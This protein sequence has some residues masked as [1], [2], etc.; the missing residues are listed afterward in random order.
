MARGL[1]VELHYILHAQRTQQSRNGDA[2][3]RVDSV[4]GNAE[5]GLGNG[6]LVDQR[7][8][9]HALDVGIDGVEILS[10]GT[11]VVDLGET[12]LV[13]LGQAQHLVALGGVDELALGVEQ[14]QGVPMLRVVRG[15]DDNAAVG[16]L[17]DN[18]HLGGRRRGKAGLD[19]VDAHTD[20]GAYNQTVDHSA[21]QTGIATDNECKTLAR[22]PALQEGGKS[23]SEFN[24]IDRAQALACGTANGAANTRDGFN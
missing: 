18:G 23:R 12:D 14:L 1:A 8:S 16:L 22:L 5:T 9:Q 7:Q 2:A 15:G 19:D 6:L 21:R 24:D 3:R 10:D 11:Q 20:K 4:D 13:A 17:V